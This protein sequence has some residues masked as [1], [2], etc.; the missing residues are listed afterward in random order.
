MSC[1]DYS[2]AIAAVGRRRARPRQA[3]GARAPRRRAAR[4]AV[5]SSQI[6]ERIQ[7]AA[8]TLD[9]HEPPR[10]VLDGAARAA[11]DR[12]GAGRSRPAAGVASLSRPRG[13]GWAAAAALV[14]CNDW[15]ASSRCP[16]TAGPHV[17]EERARADPVN[18]PADPVATVVTELE[19][20][21]GHYDKAIQ[22]L[23]Q[24]AKSDSGAL[25]PQLAGVLQ[26]NLQ[27]IDQAIGESRAAAE[28]AAGQRGRAG[29][30]VRCDAVESHAAAADRGTH[31]RNAQ[32]QS[33]RSRTTHSGAEPVAMIRYRTLSLLRAALLVARARV[34]SADQICRCL[35]E[36][37]RASGW[38]ERFQESRQGAEQTERSPRLTRSGPTRRARLESHLRRRACH[39]R[40]HQ[41]NS[42]RSHQAG[43][44]SRPRGGQAT[45]RAAARRSH[46]VGSRLEVRTIYPRTAGRSLSASVDYTITVPVDAAVSVK[47]VS[48]DVAV[49]GVRGEVRAET[50]SG[51]VDV[52]ATPNLALAKTV[53]G[54]VRARDIGAETNLSLVDGQR[55][56]HRHRH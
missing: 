33:G 7:A 31:Q 6:C 56:G 51:D 39:D 1:S 3:A 37:A 29:E 43:A 38:L 48:G 32:G 42:S 30:S 45:A 16:Q 4:R 50:V 18:R 5:R 54:D 26:K 22:E 40:P 27:V 10:H 47:T 35:H 24:I 12:S 52:V 13:R 2:D 21:A 49:N 11:A 15:L 19:A 46:Q 20:A 17:D 14:R 23:E 55:H 53:S 36:E 44:A 41:R 8:F 34:G 9:R 28:D 25:D